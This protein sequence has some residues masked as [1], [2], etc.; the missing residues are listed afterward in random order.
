MIKMPKTVSF[1]EE[2]TTL[3][4]EVSAGDYILWLRWGHIFSSNSDLTIVD[5][6]EMRDGDSV[7]VTSRIEDLPEWFE[8]HPTEV[9]GFAACSMMQKKLASGYKPGEP[10]DGPNL[11][12]VRTGDRII[13]IRIGDAETDNQTLVAFESNALVFGERHVHPHDL[14]WF[15]SFG[16]PLESPTDEVASGLRTG[17]QAVRELG[18]PREVGLG[19]TL[20]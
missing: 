18:F 20:G 4:W 13:R 10:L 9:S 16:V 1:F 6:W 15:L 8:L 2:R 5:F 7:S 19:W 14:V 3:R 12:R 17:I 11:W